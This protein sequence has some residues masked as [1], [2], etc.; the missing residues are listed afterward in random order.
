MTGKQIS[1]WKAKERKKRQALG[2]KERRAQIRE[3]FNELKDQLYELVSMSEGSTLSLTKSEVIGKFKCVDLNTPVDIDAAC[4]KMPEKVLQRSAT[5][6]ASSV[7]S[8]AH[9]M[10]KGEPSANE[11]GLD[12][13]IEW[14]N[15]AYDLFHNC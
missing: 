4:A 8:C 2:A 11:E 3:E 7:N 6:S 9:L 12:D 1:E 13:S 14:E 10:E 5:V 15:F